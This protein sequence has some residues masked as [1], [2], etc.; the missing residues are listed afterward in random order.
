MK[1]EIDHEAFDGIFKAILV[2]DLRAIKEEIK[3]LKGIETPY[4]HHK[5]DLKDQKK[6]KKAYERLIRYTH[7]A[8]EAE[9]ILGKKEKCCG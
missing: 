4:Q 2:D 6:L 3:R 8:M 1:I 9:E 7:T 5:E